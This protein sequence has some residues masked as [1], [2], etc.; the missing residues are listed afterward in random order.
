ML[1]AVALAYAGLIVVFIA[2]WLRQLRTR[3]AGMVDP[4]W[5]ASLAGVAVLAAALGTGATVNRVFVALAGGIWGLRLAL[6]LWQRN[7]GKPE[8]PR[9]RQFR[10]QWGDA[11][12]RNMFWFFQL[13]AAISMALSIAFFIPAFRAEAPSR[14]ALI[15]AAAIWLIALTGEA[16]ADRQLRRFVAD[17]THRGQV[18][19]SGWWRYSRHPNYFFECV[20][21][22]AYAVLSLGMPWGWLTLVPPVLMA[23]LLLKI[24]GVPMLEAR[25]V[26][27]RP[28]YDEYMR[29]TSAM[30]PWPPKAPRRNT[31]P[32]PPAP[33][34]PP[35]PPTSGSRS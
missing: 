10:E 32:S 33:P 14:T 26:K 19:Q 28:G 23:V 5:A 34:A 27:T 11:A 18:C 24:S 13:Q 4:V 1:F 12:N 3:D 2:A 35:A 21:W 17:P 8:D 31:T 25:L 22:C 29:T 15:A 16:S 6:H 7:H 30:V 20:H 9:Y